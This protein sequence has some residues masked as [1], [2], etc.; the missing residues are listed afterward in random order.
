MHIDH[1]NL[2][3]EF[4]QYAEKINTLKASDGHFTHLC[5]TYEAL[6]EQIRKIERGEENLSDPELEALKLK[7][8]HLKDQ[9]YHRLQA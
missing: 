9:L 1:H 4:P 8:V 2:K 3:R 6:D 7:R 5:E